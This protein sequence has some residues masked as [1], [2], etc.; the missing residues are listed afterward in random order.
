MIVA[1]AACFG[2]LSSHTVAETGRDAL[3]LTHLP[4][5]RLPFAYLGIG[6]ASLVFARLFL[7]LA[8]RFG[9]RAVLLGVLILGAIVST[10]FWLAFDPSRDWLYYAYYVW[11]GTFATT[12]VVELW[13][14]A[15]HIFTVG[16]GKRL[17]GLIAA[18]ASL[19]TFAGAAAAAL[20][21]HFRPIHEL[22]LVAATLLAGTA[23]VLI[24]VPAP[25]ESAKRD[26]VP[27]AESTLR[28][29]LR[30]SYLARLAALVGISSL[31]LMLVDYQFKVTAAAVVPHVRLGT[32]L[33]G[34]Y[35]ALGV[36]SL[37]AQAAAGRIV[38]RV[39]VAVA[40]AIMPA[41]LLL[42]TGM[43][44]LVGLFPAVLML[45]S[46]DGTL[47]HSLHRVGMELLYMPLAVETRDRLKAFIDG[48]VARTAQAAASLLLLVL[49]GLG[50]TR[51]LVGIVI[52]L[53]AALWWLLAWRVRKPYL[54]Q[55]LAA[56]H[57]GGRRAP[58]LPRLGRA[59]LPALS[60]ALGNSNDSV[61]VAAL[62]LLAAEHLQR[63]I[64]AGILGHRSRAV[65]IKALD[66]LG[67]AGRTDVRGALEPLCRHDDAKIRIAAVRAAIALRAPRSLIAE[68]SHDDNPVVQAL[69]LTSLGDRA[70]LD[71]LAA[72]PPEVRAALLEASDD[73]ARVAQVAHDDH[74][75]VLHAASRAIARLGDP[76]LIPFAIERLRLP[77]LRQAF[78]EALLRFGDV[79][80]HALERTLQDP[81]T[82]PILRRHLPRA[83][84]RFSGSRA[85]VILAR[86]L[87]TQSDG[88]VRFKIL[89][90][91]G[92]LVA[93]EPR[94]SL[95]RRPIVRTATAMA[96]KLLRYHAWRAL[97]ARYHRQSPELAS[98]SGTL[99]A[100][101]LAD[102]I[103]LGGERVFRMLALLHPRAHLVDVHQAIT[104]RDPGIRAAALEVLEN[105]LKRSLRDWV[106]AL[107]DDLDDDA[108]L[109]QVAR[110]LGPLPED[111]GELLAAI[112]ESGDETLAALA[113][114]HAGELLHTR[115]A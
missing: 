78:A 33:G 39:G 105:L 10:L 94:V 42:C 2:I 51:H 76:R 79:A 95:R 26:V 69:C 62:E 61:V 22:P 14:F 44:P 45:R 32:F 35:A 108:R 103:R 86:N 15:S 102:K 100:A 106:L 53:G 65:L 114:R 109:A 110:L 38:R 68:L 20:W 17:F 107:Y 13:L 27:P 115:A 50:M 82:D 29:V 7:A 88:V 34:M 83:I 91:L 8:R 112:G 92:R 36:T 4:P 113:E 11:V 59:S 74:P 72:G 60:A 31:T 6:L 77:Q 37:I 75:A 101:L 99:L 71:L 98:D 9:Q 57:P 58:G 48:T 1:F 85:A 73:P 5:A 90:A 70:R 19:G 25:P 52:G 16:Q 24:A 21:S 3:F 81:N 30:Q 104:R 12:A 80:L 41:L 64:P 54:E 28:E 111:Y 56:L 55:F 96:R 97:L 40:L 93:D 67:A 49:A 63:A 84:G 18:G 87:I 47:R 23:L 43:M 89:R 46:A 66:I